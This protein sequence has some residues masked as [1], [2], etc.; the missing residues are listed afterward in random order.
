[1]PGPSRATRLNALRQ[2]RLGDG[3]PTV[4]S[5]DSTGT[6]WSD[7]ELD[8]DNRGT[9]SYRVRAIRDTDRSDF[10]GAA[11]AE[12]LHDTASATVDENPLVGDHN[13]GMRKHSRR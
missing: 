8:T 1:M 12:I 11:E 9:Y 4:V 13:S 10:S 2:T 3:Q 6:T 5:T 7:G